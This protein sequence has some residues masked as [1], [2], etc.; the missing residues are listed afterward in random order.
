MSLPTP[1]APLQLADGRMVYPGGDI[2]DPRVV[3]DAPRMLDVPSHGEAQKLIMQV[4]RKV[5]DLPDVP[6]AMNTIG[7]VLTYTLYGL[8]DVEIG[9]ATGLSIEQI[10]RI[11]VGD[12]YSQMYDA[13]VRAV[14]DT[15]TAVVRD[16]FQKSARNAAQVVVRAMEE[17][18]RADRVAAARDI[19]DRAGHRP[20]DVVEHRHRMDGGLVI[21]IVRKDTSGTFPVV[22]MEVE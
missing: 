15:E 21:E 8:D 6:R 13:V 10:G 17:G 22:D 5:S 4:R 19:L 12:P 14:L 20:S 18:T 3:G 9:V 7:V 1:N 16:L 2:R 11:K